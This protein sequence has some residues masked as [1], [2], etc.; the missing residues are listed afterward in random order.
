MNTIIEET[1]SAIRQIANG[2][3]G[4]EIS[5]E[6]MIVDSI[7]LI[8]GDK[9]QYS[10]LL[11]TKG[12]VD[13]YSLMLVAIPLIEEMDEV[14]ERIEALDGAT[15]SDEVIAQ[16]ATDAWVAL[17]VRSFLLMAL[18]ATLGVDIQE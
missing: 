7:K 1:V 6:K 13:K 9:G 18:E 17:Q 4:D 16:T 10:T 5:F 15:D 8:K 11:I 12:E 3:I 14:V 2:Y